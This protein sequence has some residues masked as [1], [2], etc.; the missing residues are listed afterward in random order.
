MR[1]P[2]PSGAEVGPDCQGTPSGPIPYSVGFPAYRSVGTGQYG[3]VV[4]SLQS[5]ACE[6][7]PWLLV[8]DGE[9]LFDSLNAALHKQAVTMRV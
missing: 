1:L 8:K 3:S 6:C 2:K 5:R 4:A 7:Q 9:G